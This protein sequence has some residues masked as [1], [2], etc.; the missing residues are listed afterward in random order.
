MTSKVGGG[1]KCYYEAEYYCSDV[2]QSPQVG[3]GDTNR[4]AP[5]AFA[6]PESG[7]LLSAL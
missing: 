5:D 7:G 4:A 1:A 3:R 6:I 2:A